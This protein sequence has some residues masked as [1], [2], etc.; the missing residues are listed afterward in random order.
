MRYA[1]LA[2]ALLLAFPAISRPQAPPLSPNAYVPKDSR[3]LVKDVEPMKG[4]V[5]GM[6]RNMS[7]DVLQD[8]TIT[9]HNIY[10]DI[11]AYTTVG[12]LYPGQEMPWD[13][14]EPSN[15][16]QAGLFPFNPFL[17]SRAR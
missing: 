6:V 2:I 14:T 8:V 7:G 5:R 12:I 4:R 15:I 11:L 10:G 9:A 13:I 16:P 3:L 17:G 1:A